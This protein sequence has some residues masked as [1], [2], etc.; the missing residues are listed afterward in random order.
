MA[1][2]SANERFRGLSLR[3]RTFFRGAKSDNMQAM[4]R[5][6]F[7]FCLVFGVRPALGIKRFLFQTVSGLLEF[8]GALFDADD[9]MGR[10]VGC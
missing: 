3:A 4:Q 10:L 2:R 9:E 5:V 7:V 8:G 6:L 1:V